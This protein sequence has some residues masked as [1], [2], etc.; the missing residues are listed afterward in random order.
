MSHYTDS[1]NDRKCKNRRHIGDFQVS[2]MRVEG[3]R[4]Y[5]LL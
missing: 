1:G 2:G 3:G 5:V 4:K